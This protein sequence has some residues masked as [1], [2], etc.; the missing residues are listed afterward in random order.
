[1]VINKS[2]DIS[3]RTA[4]LAS[5]R[6]LKVGQ[7]LL[8]TQRFGQTEDQAKKSGKVRVWRRY[9]SLPLTSAPMA[10][11]ITPPGQQISYTDYQA[12]LQQYGDIVYI[13]DVI[14]DTH[15][16]PVLKE[17][18][19]RCGEQ[20]AQ[21]IELVTI[22]VLKAGTNVVYAA[23]VSARGSVLATVSRG[24]LRKIVR[25]FNRSYAM[26][27]S[28]II[29][30]TQN[31]STSGVEAGWYAMGHTDLESD[32]RNVSGFKTVV[33]YANPG[34]A[35]PGECGAIEKI[36]FVLTAMWKPWLSAG[37]NTASGDG[38][39]ARLAGGTAPGA[40][41][42]ACDVYP[43]VVVARDSYAIV[44]LQGMSAVNV[45]VLHPKPAPSDP[46]GQRGSVGWKT[47]YASAIL[48]EL[49][50]CRYEVACTANPT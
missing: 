18:M 27:I 45:S 21:I 30:P 31:E 26:P 44:R 32:I 1:M 15:E 10:E 36:R 35:I 6:L 25:G 41:A 47:W 9:N 43:I 29:S 23:G 22:D 48:N 39:A 4:V 40:G 28:R 33:E 7:P 49:W 24:D 8:T 34:Q 38:A 5:G 12:V 19:A 16:D 17:M 37:A 50:L 3:Q 14:E 13:T 20:M 46:L 42:V 11:G 2:G